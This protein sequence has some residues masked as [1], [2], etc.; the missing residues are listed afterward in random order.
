MLQATCSDCLVST[1]I[2]S[3]QH[4]KDATFN[5]YAHSLLRITPAP[6]LLKTSVTIPI[7]VAGCVIIPTE[8]ED[9]PAIFVTWWRRKWHAVSR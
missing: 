7:L 3:M 9:E 5:A 6:L 2:S 1:Y 4:F 8:I